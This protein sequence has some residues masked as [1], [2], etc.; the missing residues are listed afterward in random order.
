MFAKINNEISIPILKTSNS[1]KKPIG[2]QRAA[3]YTTQ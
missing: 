3:L 2:D 1:S